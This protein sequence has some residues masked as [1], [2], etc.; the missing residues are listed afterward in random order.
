MKLNNIFTIN[1][2]RYRLKQQCHISSVE[3]DSNADRD[4]L[5]SKHHITTHYPMIMEK[6]RPVGEFKPYD[7][8]RIISILRTF[9]EGRGRRKIVSF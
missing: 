1:F 3:C 4:T 8:K 2:G 7:L 9:K 5:K 6:L